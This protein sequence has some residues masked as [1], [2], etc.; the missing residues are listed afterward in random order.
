MDTPSGWQLRPSP[1]SLDDLCTSL[2]GLCEIE[3]VMC[4]GEPQGYPARLSSLG[5]LC[6]DQPADVMLPIELALARQFWEG[7]VPHLSPSEAY[8][9]STIMGRLLLMQHHGAPT[10]LLDWTSSPWVAAYFAAASGPGE[11]GYV[12][13]FSWEAS[14]VGRPPGWNEATRELPPMTD[15]T[16]FYERLRALGPVAL[17]YMVHVST[18]R[19]Y[20]QQALVTFAHPFDADHTELI[21]QCLRDNSGV[22]LRIPARLKRPLM[23]RL[24]KMNVFGGALFPGLDGVGRTIRDSVTWRMPAFVLQS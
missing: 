21:G 1:G 14:Q 6:K 11:D 8:L 7:A 13:A 17:P 2:H 15:V 12:W 4:R 3:S 24:R 22:V 20:A 19:T 5:R 18:S 16:R 10:R 23:F 9:G